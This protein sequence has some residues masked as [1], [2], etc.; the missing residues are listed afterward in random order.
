MVFIFSSVWC[1]WKT[2][3]KRDDFRSKHKMRHLERKDLRLSR[4][5]SHFTP[6]MLMLSAH[7]HISVYMCMYI[8]IYVRT[9]TCVSIYAYIY[10]HIYVHTYMYISKLANHQ[11]FVHK[12]LDIQMFLNFT[13]FFFF[14]KKNQLSS[15]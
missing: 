9:H 13:A 1:E 10:I 14:F 12:H 11:I 8:N 6:L 7:T 2:L 5:V 15:Y 4:G 3:V